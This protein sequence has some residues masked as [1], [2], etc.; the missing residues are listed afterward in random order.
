VNLNESIAEDA[1]LE[2]FWGLDNEGSSQLLVA[3]SSRVSVQVNR[4]WK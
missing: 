3:T 2:W 1:T 4:R